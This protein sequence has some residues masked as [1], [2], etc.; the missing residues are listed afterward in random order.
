MNTEGRLFKTL[1][2][3]NKKFQ[4]LLLKGTVCLSSYNPV[5]AVILR[6]KLKIFLITEKC[7]FTL[8]KNNQR[9]CTK[10]TSINYNPYPI[11]YELQ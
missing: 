8:R 6:L 9:F 3:E 5:I 4:C 10:P 11:M 2:T 7:E 1:P